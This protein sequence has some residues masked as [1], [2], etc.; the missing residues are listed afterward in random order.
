MMLLYNP[1][2]S[3][4][5]ALGFDGLGIILSEEVLTRV[6]VTESHHP[7]HHHHHHHILIMMTIIREH[8]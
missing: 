4:T 3:C 1:A 7:N 8:I 6:S 2:K 5:G